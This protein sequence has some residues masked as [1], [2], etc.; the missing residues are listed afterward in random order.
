MVLKRTYTIVIKSFYVN[1][2]V[3]IQLTCHSIAPCILNELAQDSWMIYYRATIY[4]DVAC[5]S[6]MICGLYQTITEH[7]ALHVFK[8]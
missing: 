7:H 8:S 3:R 5:I 4:G 1:L 6:D 2:T